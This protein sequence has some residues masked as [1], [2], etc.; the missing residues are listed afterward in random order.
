MI[1]LNR[2]KYD[3]YGRRTKNRINFNFPFILDLNEYLHYDKNQG[4]MKLK[5]IFLLTASKTKL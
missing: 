5:K 2:V 4:K 1:H 3:F